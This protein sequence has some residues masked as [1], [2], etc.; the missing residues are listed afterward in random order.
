MGWVTYRS[1]EVHIS[2]M[3]TYQAPPIVAPLSIGTQ[4]WHLD[5]PARPGLSKA[6]FGKLFVL[7]QC[8]I[9]ATR[10]QSNSH[11]CRTHVRSVDRTV[12]RSLDESQFLSLYFQ[13]D[14]AGVGKEVFQ[15]MFQRCRCGMITTK[16]RFS[17]HECNDL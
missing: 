12:V 15:Q 4:L 17:I 10:R 7:C 13:L 11:Q 9:V 3:L 14:T 8:G 1:P 6:K 16:R 5:S 2:D